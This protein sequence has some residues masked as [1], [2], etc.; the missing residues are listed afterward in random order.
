MTTMTLQ[1]EN[2]SI[3]PSLRKVLGLIEGVTISNARR[4][5]DKKV[6]DIPNEITLAA[7][8]EAKGSHDAGEVNLE[9]VDGFIASM[10]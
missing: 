9:N 5:T 8:E 7:M 10:I 6:S 3:L 1:I 4:R 2:S